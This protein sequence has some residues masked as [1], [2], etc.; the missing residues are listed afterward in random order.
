MF[1]KISKV[2]QNHLRTIYL[3]KTIGSLGSLGVLDLCDDS[4]QKE[5]KMFLTVIN[6]KP[7][8]FDKYDININR[9]TKNG[10]EEAVI[11]S[12]F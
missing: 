11:A 12:A 2:H 8:E 7:V 10:Q 4:V 6:I 1:Q 5:N 3:I 9:L